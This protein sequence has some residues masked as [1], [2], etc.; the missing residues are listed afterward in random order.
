MSSRVAI[1]PVLDY[2]LDEFRS[3]HPQASGTRA[4]ESD[5][6][7]ITGSF[8]MQG[9][10]FVTGTIINF[11]AKEH[12]RCIGP[13]GGLLAGRTV[14]L[15]SPEIELAG[16]LDEP[17]EVVAIDDLVL[18]ATALKLK[19]VSLYLFDNANFSFQCSSSEVENVRL[20]KMS[21]EG[22]SLTI[23]P[24]QHWE[25]PEQFMEFAASFKERAASRQEAVQQ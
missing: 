9:G 18:H 3:K 5:R 4:G 2:F 8:Q 16:S 15:S 19:N 14:H 20:F 21:L 11:P 13:G 22:E 1:H 23:A 12:I 17:I 10:Y 25:N 6:F 7:S 24:L